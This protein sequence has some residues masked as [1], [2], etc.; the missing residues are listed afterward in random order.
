MNLVHS[1]SP[2]PT[3]ASR[4]AIRRMSG[5]RDK[6]TNRG[7]R[8]GRYCFLP[9]FRL[10]VAGNDGRLA[11][12]NDKPLRPRSD[13]SVTRTDDVDAFLDTVK[14]LPP[15]KTGGGAGRLIFA[16]DATASR[17]PTWDRAA[18]L[19]ADMFTS[20]KALGQLDVQL[21]FYRGHAECHASKWLRDSGRLL[22][23]MQKVTCLA[24][25]TQIHRVLSHGAAE[26][27]TRAV[28]ALVFVGDAVEEDV[29]RLGDL[30][31]RLKLLGLPVFV[32]QEGANPEAT[33]A[34]SQIARLSGGA[35]CRFDESS[36]AELGALLGA[37][38][39]Y[40]AGGREALKALSGTSATAGKLLE[41]L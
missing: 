37:V 12:M 22:R 21:V 29:D 10:A 40:A 6:P 1:R 23:L 18:S 16:L 15:A 41:Q 13:G 35:H 33:R 39:A 38:A 28:Q 26:A 4:T 30:A 19:Q 24:G 3:N 7:S 17:Q 32:F 11:D 8:T 25:R 31:G 34:F 14:T 27:R 5:R 36:A 20:T 2:C 9:T